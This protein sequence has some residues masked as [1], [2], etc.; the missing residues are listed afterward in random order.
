[1]VFDVF[2]VFL[3]VFV[4]VGS[5]VWAVLI[6]PMAIGMRMGQ[7]VAAA[8]TTQAAVNYPRWLMKFVGFLRHTIWLFKIAMENHHF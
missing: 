6:V 5:H 4:I 7:V 2:D 1:M 3:D 8:E